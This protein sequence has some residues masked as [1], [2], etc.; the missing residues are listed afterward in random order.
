MRTGQQGTCAQT[1]R[2]LPPPPTPP[3]PPQTHPHTHT[4]A[5][6]LGPSPPR[7][8]LLEAYQGVLRLQL[9]GARNLRPADTNGLSDPY[10]VVSVANCSFRTK[11]VKESLNPDWNETHWVY[12][13]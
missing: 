11:T 3:S 6:P 13:R 7:S 10:A 9:R 5:R 2:H 8:F 1:T 12:I 4:H